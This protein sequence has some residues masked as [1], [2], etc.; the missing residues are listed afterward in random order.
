MKMIEPNLRAER[1]GRN[2]YR[3]K[4]IGFNRKSVNEQRAIKKFIDPDLKLAVL[5]PT[6]RDGHGKG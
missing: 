1:E 2:H 3:V 6:G 5:Q 4:D